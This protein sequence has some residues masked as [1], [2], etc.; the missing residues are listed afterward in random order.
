[1]ELPAY[2][3][4]DPVNVARLVWQRGEIFLRRA[5]TIILS[6]MVIVWALAKIPLPP[7]GAKGTAIDYSSAGMIGRALE[8]LL[9]PIGFSWQMSVALIP[10]MAAREV[11]VGA[12]GTVYAV[13]GGDDNTGSLASTLSP[14][15]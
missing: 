10:G 7:P 3:L 5:G 1:M 8:P 6:M 12:L 4:P 14:P 13:G 9:H 15:L 2:K 11:A